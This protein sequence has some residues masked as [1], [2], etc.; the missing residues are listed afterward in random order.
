MK[1]SSV[2]GSLMKAV[3]LSN[4]QQLI[5]VLII[6]IY[7]NSVIPLLVCH[8]IDLFP[9][10]N[11]C[12]YPPRSI[13]YSHSLLSGHKL[14]AN[15]LKIGDT[16]EALSCVKALIRNAMGGSLSVG[17]IVRR[18][19]L[20]RFIPISTAIVILMISVNQKPLESHRFNIWNNASFGKAV[21]LG[22]LR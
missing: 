5:I 10:L 22:Q 14:P 11:Y 3:Q 8:I 7:E 9:N 20:L 21:Q 17:R 16:A 2:K 13:F 15:I 19:L 18:N 4:Y 6:V 12:A 1:H